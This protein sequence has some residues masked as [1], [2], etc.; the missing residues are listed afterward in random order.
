MDLLFTTSHRF[1]VNSIE[2]NMLHAG[3][4]VQIILY[5]IGRI[6]HSFIVNARNRIKQQTNDLHFQAPTCFWC[7]EA[8]ELTAPILAKPQEQPDEKE[9]DQQA[10]A[11]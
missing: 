3:K 2:I 8:L 6:L 4:I 5:K 11:A 9:P 1:C 7:E 10:V